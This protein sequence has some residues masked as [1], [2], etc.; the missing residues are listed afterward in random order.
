MPGNYGLLDQVKALHWVQENI[1]RFGGDPKKVTIFGQSA[2]A[3][4][5]ALHMLSPLSYGLYH[6]VILES[7]TAA[8]TFAGTDNKTA[9]ELARTLAGHVGCSMSGLKACLLSKNVSEILKAQENITGNAISGPVFLPVVDYHFLHDH[10]FN[11]L[12]NG[13]FNQTVPAIIGMTKNGGGFFVLPFK[14]ISPGVPGINN[15]LSKTEFDNLVKRG[16]NW[17]YN[18]TQKVVDAT[19]FEY[20]DWTNA[21]NLLV[22]R[23][24]YMDVITDALFKAPAVRSAQVFVKNNIETYFYCFDYFVSPWYPSWSGV[25]HGVDLVY[26]FGRPFRKYNKSVS[27]A[28]QGMEITFSK[29]IIS[30]WSNFAKT[31][32]PTAD[33]N[34]T[35]WPAYTLKDKQF[36]SLSPSSSIQKNM[37]PE[38]MAFWNSLVPALTE[39]TETQPPSTGTPATMRPTGEKE[40]ATSDKKT[41]NA[42]IAVVVVLAVLVLVLVA[43]IWW[44]RRKQSNAPSDP[45]PTSKLM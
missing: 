6:K 36:I 7:G 12:V 2:G 1:E 39:T 10:P 43:V 38:K 34:G 42:L 27:E 23:Q 33:V 37:L 25:F 21:T 29:Q 24:K 28:E 14:G 15:G 8:S 20:T 16:T 13:K 41:E 40:A 45:G 44:I 19:I 5:V 32:K 31:G 17:V 18:Q 4:S 3:A 26:V 9:I 35:N 30:R 11:L 22:L